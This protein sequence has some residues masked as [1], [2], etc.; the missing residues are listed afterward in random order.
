MNS[1]VTYHTELLFSGGRLTHSTVSLIN[2]RERT[3]LP[4]PLC[5]PSCR[6]PLLVCHTE[7][8]R[9]PNWPT[10]LCHPSIIEEDGPPYSPYRRALDPTTTTQENPLLPQWADPFPCPRT[11]SDSSSCFTKHHSQVRRVK[12]YTYIS[13]FSKLYLYLLF[14][15]YTGSPSVI[16]LF[17]SFFP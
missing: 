9:E 16:Y 5:H 14:F 7:E 2:Q 13:F 8:H 1:F 10:L 12:I 6:R 4:T 11:S 15:F 17:W 3:A